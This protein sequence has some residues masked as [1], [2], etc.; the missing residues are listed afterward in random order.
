MISINGVITPMKSGMRIAITSGDTAVEPAN[1]FIQTQIKIVTDQEP[2]RI[3][4][5]P[6]RFDPLLLRETLR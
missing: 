1:R 2:R 4:S 5:R 6:E 3:R